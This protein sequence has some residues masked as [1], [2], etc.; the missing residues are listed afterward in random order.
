MGS[1]EVADIVINLKGIYEYWH[2]S[3]KQFSINSKM[4]EQHLYLITQ[5]NIALSLFETN[6]YILPA[7]R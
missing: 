1:K 3:S 6:I 2:I 5:L 4:Q 7:Y